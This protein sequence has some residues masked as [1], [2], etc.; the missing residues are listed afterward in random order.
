MIEMIGVLAVIA[1]LAALLIPK[2]FDTITSAKINNTAQNISTVKTA[3]V[4]H[5]SKYGQFA[6]L[7]GTNGQALASLTNYDLLLLQEG[8][9]DK[10]FEAKIGTN[11]VV[12]VVA[13]TGTTNIPAGTG[14]A[15]WLSGQGGGQNECDAGTLVVEAVVYGASIMDAIELNKRIDGDALGTSDPSLPDLKG[16]VQFAAP[17]SV[18]APVNVYIYMANK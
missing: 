5:Y 15:Y 18:G 4:N 2:V 8:L 12:Q 17:A 1:I 9:L 11:A 14:A 13:T 3:V 10:P 6:M 7:F 16:R